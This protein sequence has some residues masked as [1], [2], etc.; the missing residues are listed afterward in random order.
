MGEGPNNC[1]REE[2]LNGVRESDY[3]IVPKKA[4]NAAGGKEVTYGY[5]GKGYTVRAQ[6]R[7]NRGNEIDPPREEGDFQANGR[8]GSRVRE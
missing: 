8:M 6:S 1:N 3:L 2:G 5:A 7:S 4:G